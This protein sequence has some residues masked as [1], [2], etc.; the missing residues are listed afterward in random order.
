MLLGFK[1]MATLFPVQGGE[2]G[3]HLWRTLKKWKE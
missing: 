1:R 2:Q 3:G